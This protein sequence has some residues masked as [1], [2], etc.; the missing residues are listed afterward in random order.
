MLEET[1]KTDI[2][3]PP[4]LKESLDESLIAHLPILESSGAGGR[5][6]LDIDSVSELESEDD[7]VLPYRPLAVLDTWKQHPNYRMAMQHAELAAFWITAGVP[8]YRW[9][10]FIAWFQTSTGQGADI[11]Q[12]F[13]WL[14]EFGNSLSRTI[15]SRT[16]VT[17]HSIIPALGLPSCYARVIDVVTL[18]GICLLVTVA[19]HVDPT[20]RLT[21]S[22]L[23]CPALGSV[24]ASGGT[25][26]DLFR[27]HGGPKLVELVHICES[28]F[29]LGRKDRRLRLAMTMADGAIQ[30]PGSVDFEGCEAKIDGRG[31]LPIGECGF[32]RLD[33]GGGQADRQFP[34]TMVYDRF[35]RLVRQHFAW[36]TGLTVLRATASE[37]ARLAKGLE[38]EA[39]AKLRAATAAAEEGREGAAA[40]Y[41]RAYHKLRAHAAAFKHAGWTTFRRPLAPKADGTRKVVW[42]TSARKRL[43]DIFPLVHWGLKVRMMEALGTAHE[44]VR[45]Q[46]K[47]PTEDTGK[48]TKQMKMWRAMG[49][50][51]CDIHMLVFNI[52][53][54]DFRTKHATPVAMLLQVS[55][56]SSLECQSRVVDASFAMFDAIG[57]LMDMLAIVRLLEMIL[58]RQPASGGHLTKGVMWAAAKTLMAHRCWRQFPGLTRHLPHILL[59]GAMQGVSLEDGAFNEPPPKGTVEHQPATG[60]SAEA[61]CHKHRVAYVHRRRQRFR[62]ATHAL[63]VLLS[64]AKCEKTCFEAKLLNIGAS[65]Q[66]EP[67]KKQCVKK[68]ERDVKRA[69]KGGEGATAEDTDDEAAAEINLSAPGD[70]GLG[71][72]TFYRNS[73]D[74]KEAL[75]LEAETAAFFQ[76]GAPENTTHKLYKSV[77]T[78]HATDIDSP[79]FHNPEADSGE[80]TDNE[81]RQASV[82][83]RQGRAAGSSNDGDESRTGKG[84]VRGS[85]ATGGMREFAKDWVVVKKNGRPIQL[86]EQSVWKDQKVANM[87]GQFPSREKMLSMYGKA[88]G[89]EALLGDADTVC[90]D[91]IYAIHSEFDGK[92]WGLREEDVAPCV[93]RIP[94]EILEPC[95]RE[96]FVEEYNR[97]RQW[98]RALLKTPFVREFFIFE[99]CRLH[100]CS[101]EGRRPLAADEC[102]RQP[103]AADECSDEGRRPLVAN[104]CSDE[105]RRPLAAD[106]VKMPSFWASRQD[107]AEATDDNF[108]PRIGSIVHSKMHGKC[109]VEAVQR[110]VSSTKLLRYIMATPYLEISC[111]KIHRVVHAYLRCTVLALPSESLAECVGSILAD[112]AQK[113]TGKPKEVSAFIQA[114]VIR[115]AGLRGHGGEEGILAD[116]LN[117][118][119][120]GGG[121]RSM[122]V[123][124]NLRSMEV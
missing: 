71:E 123:Q 15:L 81:T 6:C 2:P 109:K 64:W 82:L 34:A 65:T 59:G 35:L 20:G 14:R 55:T 47:T 11:N 32:H 75:D 80:D 103:L 63:E 94:A 58:D 61:P 38:E 74:V 96:E 13:H 10:E 9:E 86:L 1:E 110:R 22:L 118:H 50:T 116:A 102:G 91:A 43:F 120:I 107:I 8:H 12:S 26:S 37:F 21:W 114:T 72:S 111:L 85:P 73:E 100:K 16:A 54:S 98:L 60:G 31:R 17:V 115:L 87:T 36:G 89:G 101:D 62:Q 57:T 25:S 78:V 93:K 18:S 67:K 104:K 113:A 41:T 124:E 69:E 52:G 23:G 79:T 24:P 95:N 56:R 49:R 108:L 33:G 84:D 106:N 45:K 117:T 28:R 19:V 27:F 44:A 105:G 121:S 76:L 83:L 122:K 3:N 66:S 4:A 119:F 70:H 68:Q 77:V 39:Q 99:A 90:A 92:L 30:G 112:A 53:R 40:R 88:F 51:L 29:R 48:R 42:Q 97:F 5:A 7:C 46:G